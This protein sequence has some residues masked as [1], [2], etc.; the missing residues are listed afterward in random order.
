MDQFISVNGRGYLDTLLYV[1][2]SFFFFF[3]V[4]STEIVHRE[5]TKRVAIRNN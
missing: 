5:L 2:I 4:S 1:L 3:N